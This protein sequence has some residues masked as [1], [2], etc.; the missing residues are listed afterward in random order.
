[1]CESKAQR[2]VKKS[3]L[4]A[5][6]NA[7]FWKTTKLTY[8]ESSERRCLHSFKYYRQKQMDLI[9]SLELY[10][11]GIQKGFKKYNSKT[12]IFPLSSYHHEL[13]N[14]KSFMLVC[15]LLPLAAFVYMNRFSV[16]RHQVNDTVAASE[17]N[18]N[19]S[20]EMTFLSLLS[21]LMTQVQSLECTLWESINS[22]LP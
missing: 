16:R 7:T 14:I 22:K 1:M 2:L 3:V 19:C 17:K 13:L 20:K 11:L 12:H 6:R 18:W 4:E 10:S 21:I 8:Q 9:L 5:A 15:S